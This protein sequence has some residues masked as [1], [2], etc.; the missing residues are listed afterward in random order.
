[1]SLGGD[2]SED[3]KEDTFCRKLKTL[4]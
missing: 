1:M 4:S 3:K 2:G